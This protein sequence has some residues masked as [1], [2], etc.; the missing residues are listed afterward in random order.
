MKSYEELEILAKKY[1]LDKSLHTGYHNYIPS[2]AKIFRGI[3]HKVEHVLEIG[4]GSLEN[5]QMGG[6]NGPLV[7]NHGYKTGNSL[8]LWN[9]FFE[10]AI[11]HGI[12]I[13][14]HVA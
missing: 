14:N 2:Y 6:L 7:L 12:D 9:D 3:K 4:I 8:K 5:G 13:F 1:A 10:D 11:I